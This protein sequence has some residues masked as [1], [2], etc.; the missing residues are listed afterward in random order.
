MSDPVAAAVAAAQQAG[1]SGEPVVLGD[2]A[3]VLVRIGPVVARVAVTLRRGRQALESELV[4][5]RVAA[6]RGAPVV[7]PADARVYEHDGLHVTFWPYVE[8]RRAEDEDAP[9]VG[10]A[11]RALHDAIADV[12]V[13]LVRFD[14]LDEVEVVAG[15]LDH[16]DRQLM[17]AA[18]AAARELLAALS[19]DERPI[20]GDAHARNTLITKRGPLWVDFENLCRGPVEYDLACVTFR[21]VVHGWFHG[22]EALVAYGTYDAALVAQLVPLVAAFLVPW[23]TYLAL[24]VGKADD[25]YLRERIEYLKTFT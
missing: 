9:A 16:P 23:N 18:I 19:L 10:R 24:R 1:F 8:H 2:G 20:H 15:E 25:P 7:P 12:D 4:L 21:T 13:P 22:R 6:A 3:N 14:R 17:L 5:T 11:L